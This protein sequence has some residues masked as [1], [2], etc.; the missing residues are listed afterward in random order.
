MFHIIDDEPMLRE[1]LDTIIDDAGFS[2]R[3]FESGEAYLRF[4]HSPDFEKPTAILSDVS[5]PGISG[6]D[7]ATA[8]RKVYPLQKIILVTGNVNNE[9]I[10]SVKKHL[11][12]ILAKPFHPEVVI[13]LLTSLSACE[14]SCEN[15]PTLEYFK[16]CKLAIDQNCP[17]H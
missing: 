6:Y 16:D 1:L 3:S 2:S 8:I 5:M 11:C 14:K 13:D 4:L 17:F 12:Y 7:L 10:Q 15:N 9:Q